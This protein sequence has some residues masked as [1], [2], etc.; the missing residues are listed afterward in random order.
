ML[1][2][3]ENLSETGARLKLNSSMVVKDE[4][5]MIFETAGV[6]STKR[7][8]NIVWV[9]ALGDGTFL[10]GVRFHKALSFQELQAISRST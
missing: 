2:R 4:I 1:L 3:V 9:Q 6:P 10:V 8:G 7:T 5:E